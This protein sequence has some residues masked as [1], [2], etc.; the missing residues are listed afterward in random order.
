MT[1]LGYALG[2]LMGLTLGILGGGGSILTVPIL[3]Y[4]LGYAP[5][6]AIG[7]SLAVVGATSA[8]G[9]AG[10]WRA[11]NVRVR[12]AVILGAFAVVGTIAGTRLATLVSGAVQLALFGAVML[13]AAV[14]MLRRSAAP[15]QV[16]LEAEPPRRA[17]W[18][19]A[20]EGLG[21][22]VLTGLVGV[23]GGFLIVPALVVLGGV[24]M[25]QAVGTSLV[26]IALNALTGFTGYLDQIAVD[27][28]FLLSFTAVAIAGILV[29]TRLSG[30]IPTR[31]LTRA[32]AIFLVVMGLFILYRS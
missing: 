31:A 13:V 10:H 24:P 5:K 20:V 19:I 3:V 7:M 26:V 32:F 18:L 12:R 14:F 9:A 25:R 6:A 27:W 23:G 15:A 11:G 29:G 4:V 8:V 2:A 1:L 28:W 21:I 30:R 22:G 17:P 16:E